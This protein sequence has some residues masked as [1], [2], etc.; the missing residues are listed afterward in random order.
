MRVFL[1][2]SFLLLTSIEAS[3]SQGK[4]IYSKRCALCHTE[5]KF[6]ASEKKAKEWKVLFE[7]TGEK[8]RLAALHLKKADTNA[9]LNYFQTQ[10]YQQDIPHLKALMQK[11]SKDRGSHNSCY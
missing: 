5:G 7:T 9:S 1:F 6:L 8:N 3:V 2:L 4:N 11:Y 10:S